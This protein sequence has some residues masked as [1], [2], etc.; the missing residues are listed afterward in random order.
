MGIHGLNTVLKKVNPNIYKTVDISYFEGYTLAMDVSIFLHKYVHSDAKNWF[1][2]LLNFFVKMQKAKINLIAV[3]DGK[4]VPPEKGLE[5][6]N[7][8]VNSI[9]IKDRLNEVRQFLKMIKTIYEPSDTLSDV[10][11]SKAE[12]LC[13][14]VKCVEVSNVINEFELLIKKIENQSASV[15]ANVVNSAHELVDCLGIKS[16]V[17]Y[18]E[19]E[20]LCASLAIHGYAD[21]VL[22]RDTDALVYGTPLFI[23]ELMGDKMTF[24]TLDDVLSS[25]KFTHKQFVDFCIMCGCDYNANIPKIACGGAFK[26]IEKYG[27][28]DEFKNKTGT[29]TMCLRYERCREI[30]VAYDKDYLVGETKILDIL[31]AP[32]KYPNEEEVSAIFEKNGC[33]IPPLY[34]VCAFTSHI[35]FES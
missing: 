28:I 15:D 17:A 27:S 34:V 9:K 35:K 32:H 2:G 19:A 6:D 7:R 25:L 5:R 13:P 3:F 22:S 31:D 29:D 11:Q 26:M 23:N 8:K 1:A 12:L 10:H 21:G 24:T 16:V 30:F 33:K 18:G 20:A 14:A 4:Y